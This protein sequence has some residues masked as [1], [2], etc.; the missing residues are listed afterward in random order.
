MGDIERR[1]GRNTGHLPSPSKRVPGKRKKKKTGKER[2]EKERRYPL[3]Q[4]AVEKRT[5]V[6]QLHLLEE[7]KGGLWAGQG[8]Q[9]KRKKKK[10]GGSP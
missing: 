9:G 6:H 3:S 7:G 10:G 2:R 4:S 5:R 1:R 8:R